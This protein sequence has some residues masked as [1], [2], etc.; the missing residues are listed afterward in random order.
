MDDNAIMK[1]TIQVLSFLVCNISIVLARDRLVRSKY[2]IKN[3]HIVPQG[4]A[5]IHGR[6]SIKGRRKIMENPTLAGHLGKGKGSVVGKGGKGGK[7]K[8]LTNAPSSQ[9]YDDF[10]LS[11]C[12]TYSNTW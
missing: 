3:N 4:R 8:G 1:N 12:N 7:G 5:T 10:N 2:N 6:K 9:P 11:K